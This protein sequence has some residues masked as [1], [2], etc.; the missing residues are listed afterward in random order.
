MN[1][2][3]T[4]VENHISGKQVKRMLGALAV[5]LFGLAN[6]QQQQAQAQDLVVVDD[7]SSSL[8]WKIKPDPILVEDTSAEVTKTKE[9][10]R[11]QLAQNLLNPCTGE[12]VSLDT[13]IFTMFMSMQ[14]GDRFRSTFRTHEKGK[15]TALVSGAP[16]NYQAMS[17]NRFESTAT[18]FETR[19]TSRQRLNRLGPLPAG[20]TQDDFFIR[21]RIREKV[22]NG[23]LVDSLIEETKPEN[24]CR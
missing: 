15:G 12:T 19:F 1:N 4:M 21:T 18:S 6:A 9:I 22:V 10:T 17:E 16:Y 5:M 23:E 2:L 3:R 14:K 13:D 8:S 20:I 7:T 24:Q 11:T